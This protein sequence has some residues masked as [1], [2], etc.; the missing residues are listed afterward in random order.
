VLSFARVLFAASRTQ[1]PEK[2]GAAVAFAN[3]ENITEKTIVI[4]IRS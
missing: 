3:P 4:V 2:S 1:V